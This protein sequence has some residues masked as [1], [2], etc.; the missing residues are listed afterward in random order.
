MPKPDF[1]RPGLA[2]RPLSAYERKM[3]ERWMTALPI[4]P[5]D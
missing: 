4:P 3:L 1:K 5:G 2:C